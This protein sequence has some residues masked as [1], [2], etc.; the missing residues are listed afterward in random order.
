MNTKITYSEKLKD[1]RW[2]KRPGIYKLIINNNLYVGSAVDLV[3]RL[4]CHLNDLLA[5]RH[6][7][8]HLQR[9]YNKYQSIDFDVIELVDE[10]CLLTDRE[11]YFID[12]IQPRY[13]IAPKAGSMLGFRHS[14][15]SKKLISEVQKGKKLSPE[16]CKKM[17]LARQGIKLSDKTRLKISEAKKGSK[18]PFYKAGARHP[19]YGVK[20]SESTL[21]K[22]SG[23]NNHQSKS[24]VLYDVETGINYIFHCLKSQCHELGLAYRGVLSAE[25]NK[26]FYRDRYYIDFVPNI[27]KRDAKTIHRH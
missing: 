19:Q 13:N 6:D 7:N 18:N 9:A 11:Q 12:S 4:R 21:I 14:D 23:D 25:R 22:I 15:E 8:I 20:K 27:P 17:S 10:I 3:K 26:R 1:P 5:N 24:G 2:Q 16:A